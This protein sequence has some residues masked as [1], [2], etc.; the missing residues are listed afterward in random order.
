MPHDFSQITLTQLTQYLQNLIDRHQNPATTALPRQENSTLGTLGR[1]FNDSPAD[2]DFIIDFVELWAALG[3]ID[4]SNIAINKI[5]ARYYELIVND[6]EDN[7]TIRHRITRQIRPIF[8]YTPENVCDA[9]LRFCFFSGLILHLAQC[10][11]HNLTLTTREIDNKVALF[12]QLVFQHINQII[13][14]AAG[15]HRFSI[16][17]QD[18]QAAIKN[19]HLESST[20]RSQ[21]MADPD[22][23]PAYSAPLPAP[24]V[25]PQVQKQITLAVIYRR[26]FSLLSKCDGDVESLH[27]RIKEPFL[28]LINTDMNQSS[29]KQPAHSAVIL[30]FLEQFPYH[31]RNA[32][33]TLTDI[34]SKLQ[35][36]NRPYRNL[37]LF[38]GMVRDIC[39]E[40]RDISIEDQLALC[41]IACEI[42]SPDTAPTEFNL[43][44]VMQIWRKYLKPGNAT[45]Q[46][47]LQILESASAVFK[48]L[49]PAQL[50]EL[51][52][53][54]T[55]EM[56]LFPNIIKDGL[57]GKM[58]IDSG[59]TQVN[60]FDLV[61]YIRSC[62]GRLDREKELDPRLAPVRLDEYDMRFY[63]WLCGQI[64]KT[65]RK[66]TILTKLFLPHKMEE[67]LTRE[68]P[69]RQY[70][71]PSVW[72]CLCC[73][74][75]PFRHGHSQLHE[76]EGGIE[77]HQP[78]DS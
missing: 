72:S 14:T 34:A 56:K 71:R 50:D 67:P 38:I 53:L 29:H 22:A 68:Q 43:L 39:Q 52:F 75:P 13:K 78:G 9:E 28:T 73:C 51:F 25:H 40:T 4:E 57:V 35:D 17:L 6:T 58:G 41:R 42:G 10:S 44:G 54:L 66:D 5:V 19:I 76:P 74:F 46:Q 27:I 11:A 61:D 1:I 64:L 8:K 32:F 12:Q 30:S 7:N 15:E 31:L 16:S 20:R 77:M 60:N 62:N 63:V 23:D 70:T 48:T 45:K 47:V 18:F 69:L 49:S 33:A 21:S 24:V 65:S 59:Q 36:Q 26:A 37:Y 2:D 3:S 55:D